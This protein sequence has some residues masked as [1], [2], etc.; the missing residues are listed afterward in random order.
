MAAHFLYTTVV[1]RGE[2]LMMIENVGL[3]FEVTTARQ[4][5]GR[6]IAANA[7]CFAMTSST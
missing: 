4:V 6:H 5:T 3:S 7:A 2:D 1:N